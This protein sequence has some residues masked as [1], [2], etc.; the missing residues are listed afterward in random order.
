MQ[1]H[2]FRWRS[3]A[4][5]GKLCCDLQGGKLFYPDNEGRTFLLNVGN[6]YQTSWRYM[7]EDSN[8]QWQFV[9][10]PLM[11]DFGKH[12]IILKMDDIKCIKINLIYIFKKVRYTLSEKLLFHS[13]FGRNNFE[14]SLPSIQA[15]DASHHPRPL[16]ALIF[17]RF[18]GHF[19]ICHPSI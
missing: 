12:W 9:F 1:R 7:P 10:F 5:G 11:W 6:F 19:P 16:I 13:F 18:M 15:P 17:L 14:R 8:L 4:F 3:L 2:M